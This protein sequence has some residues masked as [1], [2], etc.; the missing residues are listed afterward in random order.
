[1]SSCFPGGGAQGASGGS[2]G[3]DGS[4]FGTN[5]NGGN[6]S[7]FDLGTVTLDSFVLSPGVGGEGDEVLCGGG[8][9]GV[10]IEDAQ[11]HPVQSPGRTK[12]QGEGWGGGG[13]GYNESSHGLQGL[14]ILEIVP[15]VE[16]RI[17][18]TSII[19]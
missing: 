14:A 11:G 4:D 19:P 7:R 6:G 12:Y 9:G 10:V 3:G 15:R 16:S 8:G 13:A 5:Y 18:T 2:N 17:F 1:M